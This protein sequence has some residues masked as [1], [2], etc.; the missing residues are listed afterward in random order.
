MAGPDKRKPRVKPPEPTHPLQAPERGPAF[1][2]N[3]MRVRMT[4]IIQLNRARRQKL[5]ALRLD[6]ANAT[7]LSE[8][9]ELEDKLFNDVVE[10]LV[11]LNRDVQE[12]KV[13][14][15]RAGRVIR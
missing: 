12:A 1:K 4:Q 7:R 14:A 9:S 5:Q 11:D 10:E 3:P 13:T 6:P 15:Q 2:E 8:L